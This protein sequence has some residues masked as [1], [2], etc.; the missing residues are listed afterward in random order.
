MR[1][2]DLVRPHKRIRPEPERVT[3]PMTTLSEMAN[4]AKCVITTRFAH[5]NF[6]VNPKRFT[7]KGQKLFHF[8]RPMTMKDVKASMQLEGYRPGTIEELLA[9]VAE[10]PGKDWPDAIY[11]T[12][13]LHKTNFGSLG[14][15]CVMT[16]EKERRVHLHVRF[17]DVVLAG[18]CRFIGVRLQ[19][20]ER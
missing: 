17:N 18:S 9:Y 2:A 4:A 16:L 15:P 20:H 1:L 13:S 6:K 11:A 5:R 7:T 14:I 19:G 12:G 10:R 8:R 3:P